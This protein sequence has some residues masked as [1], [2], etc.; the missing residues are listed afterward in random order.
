M[1]WRNIGAKGTAWVKKNRYVVIVLLVGI[2]LMA[3]PQRSEN[4]EEPVIHTS[5]EPTLT[6]EARLEEILCHIEGA[7]TVR[8]LL[9]ERMGES[10]EYQIDEDVSTSGDSSAQRTSTVLVT[11]TDRTDQGLVRQINP[12]EYLGAV[13]VCQGGNDPTVRLAI[14]EAVSRVTGLGTD[15]ISVLKMK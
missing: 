11:G 7:G 3:L 8:V 12:P 15:R 4:G 10:V 14:T 13:V 5:T 2:I 9:T 1:D 6:M